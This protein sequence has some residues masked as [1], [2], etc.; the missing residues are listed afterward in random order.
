MGFNWD[1]LSAIFLQLGSKRIHKVRTRGGNIK[2]RAMRLDNGNFSWGSEG[3]S[4][5]IVMV[6]WKLYN[7]WSLSRPLPLISGQ[8][9]DIS[10]LNINLSLPRNNL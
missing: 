10:I 4:S 1:K 5:H 3:A 7:G 8:N 2:Y 9:Q 6:T